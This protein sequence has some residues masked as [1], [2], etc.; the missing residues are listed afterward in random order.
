M[1]IL[2]NYTT[3]Q[4]SNL[5]LREGEILYDTTLNVFRY[6]DGIQFL[7]PGTP[8]FTAGTAIADSILACDS[9]LNL[10][11]LNN[12]TSTYFTG[13][14]L[15]ASQP[16]ITTLTG[17]TSVSTGTNTLI[18]NSTATSSSISTGALV[19]NGGVGISGNTFMGNTLTISSGNL[20]LGSYSLTPSIL[21]NIILASSSNNTA[22]AYVQLDNSS[23]L[24]IANNLIVS[25]NLTV[26]GST[27]TVNTNSILVK[28]NVIS[29]NSG[30]TSPGYD[31]GLLIQRY[32]TENSSNTAST[33]NVVNSIP[34]ISFILDV[35][36][37][38]TTITLPSSAS[39]SNNAYVNCWILITSGTY[40]NYVRQ[41]SAYNS[42]TKVITFVN[43]LPG[44]LSSSTTLNIYDKTYGALIWQEANS[45]FVLGFTPTDITSGPLTLSSYANLA[46]SNLIIN[47]NSTSTSTSSGSLIVSGGVGIAGNSYIGGLL[48]VTGNITGTLATTSQ[49]NITTLAGVTSIGASDSTTLTG[50]LQTVSQPN[51]TTLDGVTSIGASDSTTLTGTLQT[52]SQPNITTLSGI[53]SI[54]ASDSTTLTGTLQTVSQPNITTLNGITSIGASDST[55]IT[56]TLQTVSQ[57]NITTLAGVTSISSSTNTLTIN[58]TA[59]S[60]STTTGALVVSGGVGITGDLYV[61][62]TITGTISANIGGGAINATTLS[63]SDATTLTANTGSTST[64]T[65][66]LVVT[67]GVGISQNLYIGGTLNATTLSASSNVT[68]T[69]N[70]GSTST[71]TGTLI[72][73]GGVGISEKLYVGT[74]INTSILNASGNVSL[75][76]NTS[77]SST[78]TGSLVVTGGVGISGNLYVGG[79]INGTLAPSSLS[80]TGTTSS[81]S[82]STGTL[83]VSGGVGIAKNIFIG[84][85]PTSAS[86]WGTGGIQTSILATTFTDVSSVT[87]TISTVNA[88]NSFARPSLASTNSGVIYT[89]AATVYISDSPLASTNVT[90]TNPYALYINSGK[91]FL[92]GTLVLGQFNNNQYPSWTTTGIC[93]NV[94]D[95]IFINNSTIASGTVTSA[96]F[97]SFGQ[98]TLRATNTGI[99]T[100]TAATVY[101]AGSPIAS[102]NQTI[103]NSYSLWIPSGNVLFGASTVSNSSSS[104][105]LIVTGGVGIGGALYTG[106]TLNVGSNLIII[107]NTISSTFWGTDG[108]KF[109]ISPSIITD[110][111]SS[112]GTN[113][114]MNAVNAIGQPT[115][116]STNIG[117]IYS[118]ASTL[119]IDNSPLAGTNV[120]INS[121]YSLYINAG[122]MRINSGITS[123]NISTGSLVVAGGVG[124]SGALNVGSNGILTTGNLSAY[125]GVYVG[126]A[127][128]TP[129]TPG[130]ISGCLFNAAATPIIDNITLASQTNGTMVAANSFGIPTLRAVNTNV[131][132]TN[133]STIYI[134]GAPISGSRNTVTNAYS[135]Y[136]ESGLNYFGGGFNCPF[137]CRIS[138]TAGAA[139]IAAVDITTTNFYG[140]TIPLGMALMTGGT[141]RDQL[142]VSTGTQNTRITSVHFGQMTYTAAN[143][144]VTTLSPCNVYIAGPPLAGTNQTFSGQPRALFVAS[145]LS[146]FYGGVDIT[147]GNLIVNNPV[148]I[149]P[150]ATYTSAW[151]LLST[152]LGLLV[153][154][155]TIANSFTAASGTNAVFTAY[156]SFG[157]PTLSATSTNVTTTNSATLYIAGAPI[158]GTNMILTNSY[159]LY[160]AAGNSYFGGSLSAVN[161][162]LIGGVAFSKASWLTTGPLLNV[163]STTITNNSAGATA[164]SAV[165]SSF[166]QPTLAASSTKT[167][168][169]ASTVYIAGQPIAGTN[170]TITNSYSLYINSGKSYFGGHICGSQIGTLFNNSFVIDI[171]NAIATRGI[172]TTFLGNSLGGVTDGFTLANYTNY[173]FFKNTRFYK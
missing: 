159:S 7:S 134:A 127:G 147:G 131:T 145:G 38:T 35:D 47:S 98:P 166:A 144:S 78:T 83:I 104:G 86:F 36:S 87:G 57:P 52:V 21:N 97:N 156:N 89:N 88:I 58:S 110:T 171:S 72:V 90:I 113:S 14:L 141:A 169:F 117:V 119:Y 32:Q 9:S 39:S 173:T 122:Q 34:L 101:I 164:A 3:S 5:T 27:T 137:S 103:T 31:G 22:N 150:G 95:Q 107:N 135:L 18:I 172:Y 99:V 161:G 59:T 65:G 123:T 167:T 170:Q 168:D 93:F 155:G 120:S 23:N 126:L 102:T 143:L 85:S 48:N 96:V 128:P 109:K 20:V 132:T 146:S 77:S 41:I 158:A 46:V 45:T 139:Q 165:F 136:V 33:G 91:T 115:L 76:A 19:I 16:N 42:T 111:N 73:T 80:V 6:C 49:P 118:N 148:Y 75:T 71:S 140:P 157:Q 26:N 100:T 129:Y 60:S 160:I 68:F 67:G 56:G 30:P 50:I 84:G 28:D 51:I 54:G 151:S 64:T 15:T 162:L 25:G 154:A 13:T 130:T 138:Y 4:I 112:T 44:N 43:A 12:L 142:T 62:G 133:A 61:S 8:T 125:Y 66:T 114:T 1:V 116:A 82:T 55:T 11:G 163:P 108:I 74:S 92:G 37:T 10:S 29:V 152:P 79:N 153:G 24:N 149:L 70:T 40:N 106:T 121:S 17:L 69:A 53:T 124:I 2:R 94:L 105:A 63:A 81:I